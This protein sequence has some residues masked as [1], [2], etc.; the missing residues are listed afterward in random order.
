MG[1]FR[2][3]P[4]SA[5]LLIVNANV[6]TMSDGRPRCDAL[7]IVGNKIAAVGS[8][9]ELAELKGPSTQL[10]DAQGCTVLPGFVESHM[11][12]FSGADGQRLLQLGDVQGLSAFKKVAQT[13]AAANPQAG[14]LVAKGS[15]YT[16]FSESEPIT[17]N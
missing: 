2:V 5:D 10:I 15:S 6:L 11:H 4:K 8:A 3:M 16:M 12:L 13:Y 14:L 1:V 17:R 7:A 9:S